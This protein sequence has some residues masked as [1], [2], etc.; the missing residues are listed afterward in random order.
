METFSSDTKIANRLSMISSQWRNWLD[1]DVYFIDNNLFLLK[2]DL[3]YDHAMKGKR[4]TIQWR[5][6]WDRKKEIETHRYF[7][8]FTR[9]QGSKKVPQM[10]LEKRYSS[11]W[12]KSSSISAVLNWRLR[13]AFAWKP[14]HS[15]NI[16]LYT[17]RKDLI[18]RIKV[19]TKL[20]SDLYEN[21]LLFSFH[22]L[23]S[24]F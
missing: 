24:L 2:H 4:K 23:W 6:C 7:F 11:C 12:T 15:V 9:L 19:Q 13:G 18:E 10:V 22:F 8:S 16:S 3:L 17:M 21:L 14:V 20:G 1:T 5:G